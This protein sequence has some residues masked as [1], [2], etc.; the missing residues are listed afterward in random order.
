MKKTILILLIL[1]L[2]PTAFSDKFTDIINAKE[3][4]TEI[5]LSSTTHLEKKGP[6]FIVEMLK[7]DLYNF[8]DKDLNQEILK[9]ET[10]P[11]AEKKGDKLQYRWI[12]PKETI[13]YKVTSTVKTTSQYNPIKEKIPYPIQEELKRGYDIFLKPT[14]HID[15]TD[16]TIKTKA[17]QISQGEKDLYVLVS[18]TANWVNKQVNYDINTKTE[19]ATQKASWVIQNKQG[20]CDE[21]TSLFIALLRAQEIPA[22]FVSGASYTNIPQEQNGNWGPHGW[23]EVYYPERGWLPYD[24]TFGQYGWIDSGHIKLKECVDPRDKPTKFTWQGRDAGINA[25]EL[26]IKAEI[27][28]IGE[29][30]KPVIEITT[31][32]AKKKTGLNSYNLVIAEIKNLKDFYITKEL[33]LA[34]VNEIEI[35]GEKKKLAI[36]PPNTTKT[37]FWRIKTKENLNQEY[38]Y[39]IPIEIYTRLDE[40][41]KTKF[42]AEYNN[43]EYSLN[44]IVKIQDIIEAGGE[45]PKEKENELKEISKEENQEI[46]ETFPEK[47]MGII[48][49]FIKWIKSIF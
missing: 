34:N 42:Q 10:E 16:P 30:N 29:I 7:T 20:V 25:S 40:K 41:G 5:E 28:E 2:I 46:K 47:K 49:R 14:K 22:R 36:L 11:Q 8:P 17:E 31:K 4:T 27:K 12:Q 23:A 3:L 32:T 24:I 35:Q 19:K 1:L 21:I 33:T 9:R 26:K 38:N 13:N 15:S 6:M 44:D 43:P 48:Q 39:E 18:K 37:L 45:I